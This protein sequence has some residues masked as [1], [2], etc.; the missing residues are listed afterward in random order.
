MASCATP[1]TTPSA[2]TG[3]GSGDK[4]VVTATF[5]PLEYLASSIGGDRVRV[6]GLVPAGSE[7]HDWEPTPG[8]I[9]LIH[10]S[11]VFIYQGA[12]LETW[13]ERVVRDLPAGRPIVVEATKGL[14]VREGSHEAA[15]ESDATRVP[16]TKVLDPHL[17]LDPRLYAREAE[18]VEAA[19][20][21]ADPEGKAVYGANLAGLLAK[22]NALEIEMSAGLASC[23][24][25]TIITSHGAFSYLAAR[26]NLEQIS[27][28][29][30]SPEEEPSPARMKAIVDIVKAQGATHIFFETLVSPKVAETLA[31]ETGTQTL[32]LD[33][34]E[35]LT[36]EGLAE[37]KDYLSVMRQ[38]L[39]NLRLA[40]GCA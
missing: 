8:A 24:R 38:N 10:N 5:Y 34:V 29:G 21:M 20:S 1:A 23:Q 6:V 30:V 25:R 7:P 32:V 31:R 3:D 2:A 40:L 28:S 12:G 15:E 17:W 37:R 27:V 9:T 18:A 33:P 36:A 19:M 22:L 11:G 16:G 4:M 35:G 26:F 39:A 14:E 13:A